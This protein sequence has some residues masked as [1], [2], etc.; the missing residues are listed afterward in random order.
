MKE[1]QA[2]SNI[3]VATQIL[4]LTQSLRGAS[5]AT[6]LYPLTH[7]ILHRLSQDT[8]RGVLFDL[9]QLIPVVHGVGGEDAVLKICSSMLE[10]GS[11][12]P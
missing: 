2:T 11:W 12:W 9:I 5:V 8:R 3:H 7:E 6:L 4:N 10:I 1:L